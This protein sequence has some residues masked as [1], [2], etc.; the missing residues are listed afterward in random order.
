MVVARGVVD[1]VVYQVGQDIPIWEHKKYLESPIL[2]DSDGPINR[3][4]KWFRQFYDELNP[5]A[6][7]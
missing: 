2:C 3:Y 5:A 6:E 7:N 1:N 4:R